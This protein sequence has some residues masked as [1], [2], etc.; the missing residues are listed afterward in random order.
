MARTFRSIQVLRAIA[1]TAVVVDHA[2]RARNLNGH[3]DLGA[4]GVDL[5]F[6]ISGFIMASILSDRTATR[7][8][9][10]RARRIFPLWL[11]LSRP[12]C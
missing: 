8:L 1:A 10:D 7:F 3:A 12:G 5:F 2:D 9:I 6:V 4:A 11:S